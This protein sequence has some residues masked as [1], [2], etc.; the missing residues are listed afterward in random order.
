MNW[1]SL[2]I[3]SET[4]FILRRNK[5][6]IIKMYIGLHVKYRLLLLDFNE[7]WIFSIYFRVNLKYQ[8]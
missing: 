1:F 4:F 5:Q 7:T 6:Y 2:Q 8:N 3:S